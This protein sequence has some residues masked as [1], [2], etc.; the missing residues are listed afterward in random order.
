MVPVQARP[1][2]PDPA[3]RAPATAQPATGAGRRPSVRPGT[4]V[5]AG[6]GHALAWILLVGAAFRVLVALYLGDTVGV[7]P[8]AYDQVHFDNV[9]RSLL[10][11]KGFTFTRPPWPFIEPGAPTAYVSFLYSLFVAAT[12]WLFDSHPLAG[13]L[14]Q[15]L[16][17]SLMPWLMYGLVRR[18]FARPPLRGEA[19]E[20]VAL[21]A[22]AIVA[23]YAYFVFYSATLMTEGFY[24]L[25]V[26]WSL[27]L[28]L[29]LAAAS[30]ARRW[31]AWGLAVT[32]AILLRQVF[33]PMAGLLF[34]YILCRG[35]RP[36]RLNHVA[37]AAG[38]A[39]LLILPWTVR[40]YRVFGRF[41]LL[42]SQTGHILWNANHPDIGDS[43]V[44]IDMFPIPAESAGLNEA[45]LDSALLRLA[46]TNI[47][48][49]PGRFV[50]LSINR[51]GAFF[52]Y[53][54][55]PSASTFNNVA[56]TASFLLLLPFMIAGLGLSLREWRRWD[57]LYLFAVAYTSI[58]IVSWAGVRYRLPVDL[59]LV[60]FAAV[61]ALAAQD[62]YH[63]AL[64]RR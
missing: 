35:R 5:L 24:L 48:A 11:S 3:A 13:R 17:C 14:I 37:I 46:L 62:L 15:A 9:A 26:L 38:I 2:T 61:A 41:L 57:L 42:N 64:V 63:T 53:W 28:T 23:G 6:G 52:R 54:P 25:C 30:T 39:A 16:I 32:L 27:C 44:N 47:A 49:D 29:D 45:E 10:A 31:A 7:V 59:V 34:L 33:M 60:P 18:L 56:R 22:A 21:M 12:Y 20:T 36:V 51:L 58:H 8:V 19:A 50:R 43:F 1:S 4:A 40:N 55:I